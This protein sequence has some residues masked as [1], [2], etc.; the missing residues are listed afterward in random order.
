MPHVTAETDIAARL[1][2]SGDVTQLVVHGRSTLLIGGQVHNSTSSHPDSIARAFARAADIGSNTVFA[3][4]DWAGLEPEEGR[5][6]FTLVDT[7][8]VEARRRGL[9]WVPLWFG[10]FKNAHSTY[11]PTW[12]RADTERFPRAVV[13]ETTRPAFTYAGAMRRPTLSVF[14]EELREADAR[15]FAAFMRHLAETDTTGTVPVVQVENEVGLLADSRDRS[16]LAEAEWQR[17]VPET[18]RRHLASDRASGFAASSL[19]AA[20]GRP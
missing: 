20:Q 19:W 16:P 14:G 13:N 11:A 17:E 18:L 12:V 7:M 1:E 2:R 5:F 8:L 4:V 9:L 3:P 6:D 10:A 15:A